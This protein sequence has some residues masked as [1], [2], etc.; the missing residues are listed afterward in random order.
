MK[1]GIHYALFRSVP[2]CSCG[3]SSACTI[4]SRDHTI[5]LQLSFPIYISTTCR[6]SQC[7]ADNCRSTHRPIPISALHVCLSQQMHVALMNMNG[8]KRV[9]HPSCQAHSPSCASHKSPLSWGHLCQ[10]RPIPCPCRQTQNPC[11]VCRGLGSRP[12]TQMLPAWP[13][14]IT[15]PLYKRLNVP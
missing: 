10:L 6:P 1:K 15:R 2:S 14:I 13:T 7:H 5:M 4:S 8:P 9:T 3:R 11:E 12:F